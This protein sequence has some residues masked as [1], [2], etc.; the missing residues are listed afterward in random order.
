MVVVLDQFSKS[1][2]QIST[3]RKP[4]GTYLLPGQGEFVRAC[5]PAEVEAGAGQT[6]AEVEKAV[7]CVK[8]KLVHS[9]LKC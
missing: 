8:G 7:K 4:S 1:V 3:C 2:C 9:H 6:P 5:S